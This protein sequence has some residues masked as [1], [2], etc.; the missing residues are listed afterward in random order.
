MG[1]VRSDVVVGVELGG[2]TGGIVGIDAPRDFGLTGNGGEFVWG[3]EFVAIDG[4]GVGIAVVLGGGSV[5]KVKGGLTT[6]LG[7]GLIVGW[8]WA[9][10]G[11][12]FVLAGRFTFDVW[13]GLGLGLTFGWMGE[14]FGVGL[15]VVCSFSEIGLTAIATGFG[16]DITTAGF[17]TGLSWE[18][19]EGMGVTIL[20]GFANGVGDATAIGS[21]SAGSTRVISSGS[22]TVG[23]D[24]HQ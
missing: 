7:V 21:I 13:I 10:F 12:G 17:E 16:I 24:R 4:N 18:T 3:S 19:L 22:S 14:D 15:A 11:V 2:L 8:R 9:G 23:G 20:G 6:G 1:G 5:G